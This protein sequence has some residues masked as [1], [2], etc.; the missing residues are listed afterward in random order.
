M[1]MLSSP[2]S[3]YSI[4]VIW[5]TGFYPHVWMMWKVFNA[6]G[7]TNAAPRSNVDK[8]K[9]NKRFSPEFTAYIERI[10]G[11]HV[12]GTEIL[13]VWIAGVLAGNYAGLDNH[14]L[15]T[16][17]LAFIALR[18]FYNYT[19]FNQQSEARGYFRSCIFIASISVPFSLI[20]KAAEALAAR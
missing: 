11:A 15:N 8:L 6:N 19:Y 1:S 20:L 13:P 7:W 17:A 14:T 2:L 5:F 10:R 4:P 18:N 12:N 16:H 3:L 9:E